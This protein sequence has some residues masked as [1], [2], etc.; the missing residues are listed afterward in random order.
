MT[1]PLT[2]DEALAIFRSEV[3]PAW[4]AA[5]VSTPDGEATLAAALEVIVEADRRGE[6]DAGALLVDEAT[7]ASFA[8]ATV[9]VR[10]TRAGE[11]LKVPA[12]TFVESADGVRFLLDDDLDLAEGAVD[13]PV[14]TTV[15]ADRPGDVGFFPPGSIDRFSPL[16][17]TLSGA[18]LSIS[19]VTDG[20]F[21]RV[22]LTTDGTQPSPFRQSMIGLYVTIADDDGSHA[23]NV[24]R[25]VLV[26]AVNDGSSPGAAGG[27]EDVAAWSAAFEPTA[28]QVSHWA[29]GSYAF[30]WRVV[31]WVELGLTVENLTPATLGTSPSLDGLGLDRGMP[32]WPFE[33][34]ESLRRRLRLEPQGP[35]PLGLL[36]KALQVLAFFG[37]D[38]RDLEIYEEGAL[39]ADPSVDRYAPN[40]PPYAGFFADLHH[41]DM[42]SP[43]TLPIMVTHGPYGVTRPAVANPGLALPFDGREARIVVRWDETG[44]PELSARPIRKLLLEVLRK[45]KP[46]GVAVELYRSTQHGY[47]TP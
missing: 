26:A 11:R 31:S 6:T 33:S 40:F 36:R 38:L 21:R 35:T 30:T 3:D 10:R 22:K 43:V 4:Y 24:G 46:P 47:P 16:L 29:T 19:I 15:V 14:D 23:A 34:A 8:R 42:P 27:L 12:G 2:F 44:V 39:A 25:L 41:A 7:R 17:E 9:F 13:V 37:L 5:L 1:A 20:A 18:G 45:A 28:P 32:A